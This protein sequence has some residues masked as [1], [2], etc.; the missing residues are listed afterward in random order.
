MRN[1]ATVCAA[2]ILNYVELLIQSGADLSEIEKIVNLKSAEFADPDERVL[3]NY[4]V[5]L[6][7]EAMRLTNNPAAAL[8]MGKICPPNKSQS[9]IIGNIAANSPT[10]GKGFQ[11]AIRYSNLLSDCIHIEL[12][13]GLKDAEFIYTREGQSYFTIQSIEFALANAV[14]LLRMVDYD[15]F[16]LSEVHLQY[17]APDYVEEYHKIFHSNLLFDQQ[18]N[19]I[20]FPI[21]ILNQSSSQAQPY[22]GK[23]LIK[24]ASELIEKLSSHRQF[25]R[26]VLDIIVKKLPTGLLNI[27]EA[28]IELNM[29][30]QT[31]HRRLK[32]ESTSFQA[33]MDQARKDLAAEYLKTKSYSISEIAFL[34][35]FSEASSFNRAFNRWYGKNPKDAC[36]DGFFLP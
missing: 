21:G 22:V 7:R 14:T 35:G 23:I 17:P 29:S 36:L 13:T 10:I 5:R 26:Q 25:S 16:S 20:V 1:S 18:E 11:Q 33:L 6:E 30:R 15:N 2:V 3:L 8:H 12:R 31:L 27:E 19:K 28:A 34:L 9:G 32:Q 4:L 24:H